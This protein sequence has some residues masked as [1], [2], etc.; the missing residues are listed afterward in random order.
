MKV[1]EKVNSDICVNDM[2][3]GQI[4]MVTEWGGDLDKHGRIVQRHE[5][6][7]ISLGEHSGKTHGDIFRSRNEDCRVMILSSGTKLEI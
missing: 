2:K 4:A 6:I 5:N 1:L 3:D 7:L